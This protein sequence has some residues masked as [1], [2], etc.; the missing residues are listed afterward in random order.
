RSLTTRS[1]LCVSG[2]CF[3]LSVHPPP[4]HRQR[5]PLPR[6]R[7]MVT[8]FYRRNDFFPVR[9]PLSISSLALASSALV[10]ASQS[11]PMRQSTMLATR[12]MT[13]GPALPH[14]NRGGQL[15]ESTSKTSMP[16][17][18]CSSREDRPFPAVYLSLRA[19]AEP[20]RTR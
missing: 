8:L 14:P 15:T 1:S 20:A 3:L 5:E 12:G 16:A 13:G 10:L 7:S 11:L 4:P 17:T 6:S 19:I 2:A 18:K 9:R